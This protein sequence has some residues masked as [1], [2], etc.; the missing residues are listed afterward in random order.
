MKEVQPAQ[1]DIISLGMSHSIGMN[2]LYR[3][4]LGETDVI[5]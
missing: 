4:N 1:S 5:V 3:L 2:I